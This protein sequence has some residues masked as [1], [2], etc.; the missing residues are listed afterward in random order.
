MSQ[1]QVRQ[2]SRTNRKPSRGEAVG[3]KETE[4]KDSEKGERGRRRE[5]AQKREAAAMA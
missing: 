2:E 3:G 5:M 4:G 1:A